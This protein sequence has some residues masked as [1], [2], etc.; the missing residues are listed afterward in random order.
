MAKANTIQ[1]RGNSSAAS[2]GV[3]GV[4]G[5]G[6]GFLISRSLR[7]ET[8]SAVHHLAQALTRQAAL[9][10]AGPIIAAAISTTGIIIAAV[11]IPGVVVWVMTRRNAS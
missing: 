2:L 8:A 6:A 9:S 3:V 4:L 7:R 10:T 5:A 11:L 1:V